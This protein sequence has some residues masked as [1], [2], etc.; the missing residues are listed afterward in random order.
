MSDRS[1]A[2]IPAWWGDFCNKFPDRYFDIHRRGSNASQMYWRQTIYSAH[3]NAYDQIIH[4]ID[5]LAIDIR[6]RSAPISTDRLNLP[7]A[8]DLYLRSAASRI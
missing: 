6:H 3:C 2:Q 7:G 4:G 5:Y 8:I 1:D